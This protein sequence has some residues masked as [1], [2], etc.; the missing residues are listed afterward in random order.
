MIATK[1]VSHIEVDALTEIESETTT[2][3]EGEPKFRN[4]SIEQGN[5]ASLFL[6]FLAL[7]GG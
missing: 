5:K 7:P 2:L 6:N 1:R 3:D 4:T